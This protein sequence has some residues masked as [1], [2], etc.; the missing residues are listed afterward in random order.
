M[1]DKIFGKWVINLFQIVPRLM[2]SNNCFPKIIAVFP[3]CHYVNTNLNVQQ[4]AKMCIIINMVTL[5]QVQLV[6]ADY[7]HLA[8][9]CPLNETLFFSTH[10]FLHFVLFFAKEIITQCCQC[11]IFHL[12]Y[13]IY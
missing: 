10:S 11:F 8:A 6:K 7:Q 9:N 12:R 13:W 2:G 3:P 1:K 4:H 5:N